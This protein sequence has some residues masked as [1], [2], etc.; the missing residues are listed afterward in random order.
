M[1]ESISSYQNYEDQ[2]AIEAAAQ[3]GCMALHIVDDVYGGGFPTW[4]S[5]YHELSF[6][7]GYHSRIVGDDGADVATALGLPPRLVAITKASGNAHDLNQLDGRG[8]DEAKSADWL[9]MQMEAY[10]TFSAKEREI[11][12]LAITGTQPIFDEQFRLIGQK[13]TEQ[14]Y[15]S[16]EAEK[17]A[18]SL[19]CGDLGVLYKP[20]GPLMAH[21]LYREIQGM[22]PADELPLDK[23]ISFQE[24]Q[25]HLLSTYRYPLTEARSILATHEPQ[26]MAYSEQVLEQLQR[27]DII[28]W[29][30]LIDQDVAFIHQYSA[31]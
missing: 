20:S 24:G 6:H 10:K 17:V 25:T 19:A 14:E 5:G 27:G 22:L 12:R 9:V 26:V 30:Q 7:N 1:S 18:L 13:A 11:G 3:I 29:Q 23:L 16:K 4:T 2:R 8:I 15:P 31:V 21:Q 28:S